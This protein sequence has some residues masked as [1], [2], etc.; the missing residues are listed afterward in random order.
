MSVTEE[1]NFESFLK[2]YDGKYWLNY[3]ASPVN[4]GLQNLGYKFDS[5]IIPMSFYMEIMKNNI[6]T[7]PTIIEKTK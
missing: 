2:S 3:C 7:N 6:G 1:K 4:Q 5:Q